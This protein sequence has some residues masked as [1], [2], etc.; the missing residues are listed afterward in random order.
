L[1]VTD[2]RGMSALLLQRQLGLRQYETAWMLLHKL[3]RAM[4]NAGREPLHGR[5]RSTTRGSVA[6]RTDCEE[7]A[8]GA[9][10]VPPS[11]WWPGKN[12]GKNGGRRPVVSA[13]R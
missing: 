2:K 11:C 10:V 4:V 9:D 1:T 12:G 5:W 6:R 7:V 8:N 3:R 13:W